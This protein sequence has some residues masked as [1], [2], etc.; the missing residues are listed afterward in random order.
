MGE[1]PGNSYTAPNPFNTY[2]FFKAVAQQL[3]A[4]PDN[5]KV[6]QILL[7]LVNALKTPIER[8][9]Y[10]TPLT[11]F[12]AGIKL[13][14]FEKAIAMMIQ[15]SQL[16]HVIFKIAG[17]LD[18][19]ESFLNLLLESVE[20]GELQIEGF[21][22][23]TRNRFLMKLPSARVE[24]VANQLKN[25]EIIGTWIALKL[26][27]SRYDQDGQDRWWSLIR[28]LVMTENLW[29]V[30]FED[31]S[32]NQAIR[33]L[34]RIIQE[35]TDKDAI[36]RCIHQLIRFMDT[37]VH[38]TFRMKDY[39]YEPLKVLLQSHF[40]ITWPIIS[41]ALASQQ[42]TSL[43]ALLGSSTDI[44]YT[45]GGQLENEG[46]LFKYGVEEEIF[47]WCKNQPINVLQRIARSLPIF[48]PTQP[49]T[50]HPFTK[51]FI[52]EF[53]DHN[54]LLA[55]IQARMNS[56]G[57]TGS[58]EDMYQSYLVLFKELENHPKSNVLTWANWSIDF[59]PK[60]IKGE[61]NFWEEWYL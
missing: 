20:K 16:S 26:L 56:F 55:E 8:E 36:E 27:W 25:S 61:R 30:E 3:S 23:L 40:E 43:Y 39:A 13:E 51:R 54:E 21:Y 60:R 47:E 14:R 52:D 10:L 41:E 28:D 48:H 49:N 32:E 42:G 18:Y 12:F 4:L 37:P 5:N 35:A 45:T 17:A 33:S 46:L 9:Y 7:H 50:W 11:G 1:Y 34:I 58:V 44:N 29:S 59:L 24:E 6:D 31:L 22:E 2:H 15:D 57:S 19:N 53:G 38:N